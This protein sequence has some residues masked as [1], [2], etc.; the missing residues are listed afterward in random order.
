MDK[1][2]DT[3]SYDR[4]DQDPRGRRGGATRR[5]RKKHGRAF[6]VVMTIVLIFVITLAMLLC[7]SAAYIKNVIIPDASLDMSDFNPNL[8]SKVLAQNPETGTY[9]TVQ[10]LY[11]EENRV[12]VSSDEIP[13]YLK[14]AA[15]AIEDKRF[16]KHNGVDWVRTAKAISLMFTGRSIQGGSTLTQQL[17]KNMTSDDE[18]TVK[19][20]VMEIFRAL[21]FEKKYTKDDILEAYLNYIYLGQGCNGVYTAAYTYFGKHVSELDLAE[22]ACLIGITNNPSKY[23]PLGHLSIT[24]PDLSLIHI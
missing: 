11:G 17:I 14:D 23:D 22:C 21:E 3:R 9:E 8:T 12:W 2:R 16:Y 5:K 24:D 13:Q 10:T 7:M 20:K 4:R 15:V 1:H 6:K 19:R 18:V